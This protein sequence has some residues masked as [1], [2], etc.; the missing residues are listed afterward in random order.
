MPRGRRAPN[1]QAPKAAPGQP[2]G[3]AGDQIQSQNVIPLPQRN[4]PPTP[5]GAGG[6]TSSTPAAPVA[7]GNPME[8]LLAAAKGTPPPNGGLLA[9]SVR[10]TEPIT[11]G[12]QI[13]AGAGPEAL[14][15]GSRARAGTVADTYAMLADLTGDP[16]YRRLAAV[17]TQQGV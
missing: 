15:G 8:A 11:T 17:A 7:A 12:L 6:G 16:R 2:Y 5:T 3:E 10:P 14:T 9:P 1:E 13:G 4:Q